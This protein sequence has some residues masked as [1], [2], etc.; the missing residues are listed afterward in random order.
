MLT[1]SK[2]GLKHEQKQNRRG[3]SVQKDRIKEGKP[4]LAGARQG[5]V[6]TVEGSTRQKGR[7]S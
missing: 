7:S 2:L 5:R 6:E 3:I 1:G 4:Q